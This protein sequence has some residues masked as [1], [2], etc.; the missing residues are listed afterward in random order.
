MPNNEVAKDYTE[1][2]DRIAGELYGIA[3]KLLALGWLIE[4]MIWKFEHETERKA[5]NSNTS[6]K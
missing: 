2:L 5:E 4:M 3:G 1:E 6:N